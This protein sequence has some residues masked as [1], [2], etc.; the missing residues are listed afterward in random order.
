[1][2]ILTAIT[3]MAFAV[4]L[5]LAGALLWL[6]MSAAANDGMV[7]PATQAEAPPNAVQPSHSSAVVAFVNTNP[8]VATGFEDD[9]DEP[10]GEIP[11]EILAAWADDAQV[12]PPRPSQARTLYEALGVARDATDDDLRSAYRAAAKQ[13]HTDT[14]HDA[15][16]ADEFNVVREAYSVLSDPEMRAKY[17][18]GLNIESE[19]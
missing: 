6:Y 13:W 7:V 4:M 15:Y 5:M 11:P 3:Y 16:A 9:D 8:P 17:D 12:P 14:N 18:A 10:G 1:M 2:D 19:E